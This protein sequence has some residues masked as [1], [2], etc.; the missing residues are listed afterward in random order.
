MAC[1]SVCQSNHLSDHH[2]TTKTSPSLC[3]SRIPSVCHNVIP[4]SLSVC[5]LQNS[6]V[7]Q[8]TRDVIIPPVLLRV[9]S[10]SVTS[11]LP[12]AIPTVKMPTSSPVQ[13]FPNDQN[14]GKPLSSIH[15]WICLSIIQKVHPST[16]HHL[17]QACQKSPL[18]VGRK[19]Q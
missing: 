3:Q 5:Q 12:S 1:P 2:T 15:Q 10:L 6:S 7:C 14:L 8:P 17:L 9:R 18:I 13:N 11:I 4:T 19:P 16:C